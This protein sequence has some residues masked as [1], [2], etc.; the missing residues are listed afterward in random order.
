MVKKNL[1]DESFS[2]IKEVNDVEELLLNET[3]TAFQHN[4]R[5]QLD[6]RLIFLRFF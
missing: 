3:S 6:T 4:T 5:L 2:V 1:D